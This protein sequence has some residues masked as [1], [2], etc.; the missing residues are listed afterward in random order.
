V[1][2]MI[3]FPIILPGI[4]EAMNLEAGKEPGQK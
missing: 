3:R 4:C 2:C 1:S